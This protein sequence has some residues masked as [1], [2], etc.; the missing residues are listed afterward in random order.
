M[1][2]QKKEKKAGKNKD[3]QKMMSGRWKKWGMEEQDAETMKNRCSI[4]RP[5]YSKSGQLNKNDK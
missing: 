4:P 1:C 3:G 2:M 5:C